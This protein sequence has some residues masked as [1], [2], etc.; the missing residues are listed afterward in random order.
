MDSNS[1]P[2]TQRVTWLSFC[3]LTNCWAVK[4]H[5]RVFSVNKTVHPIHSYHL[6]SPKNCKCLIGML[7][8]KNKDKRTSLCRPCLSIMLDFKFKILQT[9]IFPKIINVYLVMTYIYWTSPSF[10]KTLLTMMLPP[11]YFTVRM[12]QTSSLII[13]MV[14]LA[15]LF[16]T[17]RHVTSCHIFLYSTFF[18]NVLLPR[19]HEWK[20]TDSTWLP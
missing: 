7:K 11:S 3:L 9:L 4:N 6:H 5:N 14:N 16:K 8:V 10:R 2:L 20:K 12:V 17:S 1:S 13:G 15:K 18:K 19:S